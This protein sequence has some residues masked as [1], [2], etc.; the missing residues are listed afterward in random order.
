MKT[1]GNATANT[2]VR[3]LV[4]VC[5]V[6]LVIIATLAPLSGDVYEVVSGLDKLVHVVLFGGVAVLLYWNSSNQR[7]WTAFAITT[8]FAAA[9]EVVQD[10]LWY[11]SGDLWDLLAGAVGALA[12]LLIARQIARPKSQDIHSAP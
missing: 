8:V 7:I 5:Y 3:R 2:L 6:L 11:R 4:L 1:L 10:Q 12:G 9:I